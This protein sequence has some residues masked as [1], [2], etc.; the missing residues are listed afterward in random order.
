L[1][2]A[3]LLPAMNTKRGG[4]MTKQLNMGD[5]FPEYVVQT[6]DGRTLDIP[7]DLS[8]EYSVLIFYRGSW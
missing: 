5:L 2:L 4:K 1:N 3:R 8:G 7:R 6:V